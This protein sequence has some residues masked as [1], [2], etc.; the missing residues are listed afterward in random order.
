MQ[1]SR[2]SSDKD[3][4]HVAVSD[5][6]W[7]WVETLQKE[8]EVQDPAQ[9]FGETQ[10]GF[11]SSQNTKTQYLIDSGGGAI[12]QGHQVAGRDINFHTICR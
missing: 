1:M 8:Y 10:P 2:F 6:L 11:A 4:G 12:F 9:V 3:P 7:L 5:Q